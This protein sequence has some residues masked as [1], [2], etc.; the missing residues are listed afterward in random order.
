MANRPQ[1]EDGGSNRKAGEADENDR[2]DG[3]PDERHIAPECR[4]DVLAIDQCLT[5]PEELPAAQ[6]T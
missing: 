5:L 3:M 4:Y 1:V 2:Y 6:R